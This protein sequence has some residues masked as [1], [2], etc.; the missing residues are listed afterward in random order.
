M[1]LWGFILALKK[2]QKHEKNCVRYVEHDFTQPIKYFS[3][4]R[5]GPRR[6]R[7]KERRVELEK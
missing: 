3:Q 6:E 2:F 7:K 1:N 4:K 5:E